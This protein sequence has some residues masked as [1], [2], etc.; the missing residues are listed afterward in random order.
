MKRS[1]IVWFASFFL[2]WQM[3][4]GTALSQGFGDLV[5][6]PSL[7]K[8]QPENPKLS[9]AFNSL[10]KTMTTDGLRGARNFGE[11]QD[12]DMDDG[13]VWA[14]IV[15][16]A[17]P[18][19]DL[20]DELREMLRG[21]VESLGGRWELAYRNQVQV[22]LPV[23]A[24]EII[25][26]LPEVMYVRQPIK[27]APPAD[28]IKLIDP[29]SEIDSER[30]AE[31]TEVVSQGVS[32][33]GADD[34]QA[35][36]I[37]GS[38]VKIAVIDGGFKGYSTLLGSELPATV[39]VNAQGNTTKLNSSE[40]GT[41]CA[42]IIHDIAP[43]ASLYLVRAETNIELGTAKDWCKTQGIKVISHSMNYF[44]GAFDGTG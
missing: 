15:V 17:D 10:I 2:M 32:I 35:A 38:G 42:E 30:T 28:P 23:E 43:N 4:G 26:D 22:W 11:A 36:G 1:T 25:T 34:W 5:L 39:Q 16:D 33:I 7:E 3:S 24:L 13:L 19:A 29:G 8:D 21:Q 31:A 6:P 12:L 14:V 27:V 44:I 18:T 41:A 37:S 40:H 9:P 20:T